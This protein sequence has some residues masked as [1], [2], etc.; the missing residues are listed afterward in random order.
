MADLTREERDALENELR[1]KLMPII[2]KFGVNLEV[3]VLRTPPQAPNVI[4]FRR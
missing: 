1:R 4:A 3:T 2:R